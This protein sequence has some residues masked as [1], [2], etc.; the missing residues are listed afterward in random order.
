MAIFRDMQE[1]ESTDIT[2]YPG[3]AKLSGEEQK[4]VAETYTNVYNNNQEKLGY[5][6]AQGIAF[7]TAKQMCEETIGQK[8]TKMAAGNKCVWCKKTIGATST[9]P[10]CKGE[11]NSPESYSK[12]KAVK[13]V[14]EEVVD[15]ARKSGWKNG[16]GREQT[17]HYQSQPGHP[18]KDGSRCM[19]AC[20][21]GWTLDHLPT[22]D[23]SK[24]TCGSCL[25]KVNGT[26]I[27]KKSMHEDEISEAR[28]NDAQF[29]NHASKEAWKATTKARKS[30]SY[31]DHFRAGKL[32]TAA[33]KLHDDAAKSKEHQGQA[34]VHYSIAASNR[35]YEKGNPNPSKHDPKMWE[36]QD[37]APGLIADC[38]D[39][40]DETQNPISTR[41]AK[42][43]C[44]G[45]GHS[46]RGSTTSM[47][48]KRCPACNSYSW[49]S[50]VRKE[51]EDIVDNKISKP[52]PTYE[53]QT[54][55]TY[56]KAEPLPHS[57]E[58][59]GVYAK[60]VQ[61]LETEKILSKIRPSKTVKEGDAEDFQA[62]N[63]ALVGMTE[64]EIN[65]F[66]ISQTSKRFVM[67]D[68]VK[69][70]VIGVRDGE[71]VTEPV[72]KSKQNYKDAHGGHD[73][74]DNYG[75]KKENEDALA[76]AANPE[77]GGAAQQL[78]LNHDKMCAGCGSIHPIDVMCFNGRTHSEA[79]MGSGDILKQNH[80]AKGMQGMDAVQMKVEES[81]PLISAAA[82]YLTNRAKV[83]GL[84][85][86]VLPGTGAGEIQKSNLA[87]KCPNC[88][89]SAI[90]MH[91]FGS[92]IRKCAC[93]SGDCSCNCG[94]GK[95]KCV[96]GVCKCDDGKCMGAGDILQQNHAV[97]GMKQATIPQAT[98]QVKEDEIDEALC[99]RCRGKGCRR[100]NFHFVPKKEKVP[101]QVKED[102]I[103]EVHIGFKN[104]Q[105]KLEG[106]GH[107]KESAGNICHAI[108]IKKYGHAVHEDEAVFTET[109]LKEW[110]T[111][112]AK[113]NINPDDWN[114]PEP[115]PDPNERDCWQCKA[116]RHHDLKTHE[117]N[118]RNEEELINRT[119]S[120]EVITEAEARLQESIEAVWVENF[121]PAKP[122]EEHCGHCSHPQSFHES[123]GCSTCDECGGFTTE[124]V[125]ENEKKH[126]ICFCGHEYG[127]HG[128]GGCKKCKH[129]GVTDA[130]RA[131]HQFRKND[132]RERFEAEYAEIFAA[133]QGKINT[134]L[135]NAAMNWLPEAQDANVLR[136]WVAG[137]KRNNPQKSKP[138]NRK[139]WRC[140]ECGKKNP[141]GVD[142]C[143]CADVNEGYVS[144]GTRCHDCGATKE[145]H[146]KR[147][148]GPGYAVCKKFVLSPEDGGRP[149]RRKLKEGYNDIEHGD[150]VTFNHP[151]RGSDKTPQQGRGKAVMRGPGGWVVNMGGAHGTPGI[152]SSD[153]YVSHRKAKSKA[154]NS[155]TTKRLVGEDEYDDH[156]KSYNVSGNPASDPKKESARKRKN[157]A[158]K[159]RDDIRRSM[160]LTKV[161]GAVSGKT[162]WESED[163]H[164]PTESPDYVTHENRFDPPKPKPKKRRQSLANMYHHAML[165]MGMKAYRGSDGKLRYESENCNE[166]EEISEAAKCSKCGRSVHSA[167]LKHKITSTPT[168]K[169]HILCHGCFDKQISE[170][171]YESGVTYEE[172]QNAGFNESEIKRILEID[173]N[174]TPWKRMVGNIPDSM[175]YDMD[176][177]K[178]APKDRGNIATTTVPFR[179]EE[180]D[181]IISSAVGYINQQLENAGG[182]ITEDFSVH[183]RLLDNG[184]KKHKTE[185][186]TQVY[187][188]PEH[189]EFH[190]KTSNGMHSPTEHHKSNGDVVGLSHVSHSYLNKMGLK[191]SSSMSEEEMN[192]WRNKKVENLNVL[193]KREIKRREHNGGL[194]RKCLQPHNNASGNLCFSCALGEEEMN[195]WIAGKNYDKPYKHSKHWRSEFADPG[196]NSSLR[197]AS[198]SNPR[199][200]PC[201]TCKEPNKLTAKDVAQKYQCNDCAD[202]DERC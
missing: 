98:P 143:E 132:Y 147:K 189:G 169:K 154:P 27:Y 139:P 130:T 83:S 138:S 64:D 117:A 22:N 35:K 56:R 125:D 37:P 1:T 91:Q 23:K 114:K 39:A 77:E 108:M 162:Y 168:F 3:Y 69:H 172:L 61:D 174:S 10:H 151:L 48:G 101:P 173:K 191:P 20:G 177:R 110:E 21:A 85:E 137:S 78:R 146:T 129:D 6:I 199:N 82:S 12:R 198:K 53:A 100:C 163:S 105:K 88:G 175:S 164:D 90:E 66:A 40:M 63:D 126:E 65:E 179:K 52:G 201:P 67:K 55:Y 123:D 115:K 68:G 106:K 118:L 127:G 202:R 8:M 89:A 152:V 113:D 28:V 97:K 70:R 81:D 44:A 181:P 15:E 121:Y 136:A 171:E 58:T 33:A 195:E 57:G 71:L 86:S 155:L 54:P 102:E 140:A 38:G 34:G 24:V 182:P 2:Q 62:K 75:M 141:K 76:S 29:A 13:A 74:V 165:D 112:G 116:G 41:S 180:V 192:E 200:K 9:C 59:G 149:E 197:A 30:Q 16:I 18:G 119:F 178:P 5:R 49:K 72:T 51:E 131:A 47:M 45:C 184:F 25:Q 87:Q 14:R 166:S 158:R 19:P 7:A 42:Y 185:N 159:D 124:S 111:R 170:N 156:V 190:I 36:G 153:N 187:S 79:G 176:W 84:M 50:P 107:S 186:Q 167:V 104:L 183:Q 32:H 95:C 109:E 193:S 4:K 80:Q 145:D 46:M 43:V 144:P 194:C 60:N 26:G 150:H 103:D 160:G 93:A 196:G 148:A 94:D 157:Q 11:Q 128:K 17:V 96:D 135:V 133:Q 161:K 122:M 188:H 134:T 73:W 92:G 99:P 31:E 142:R 120:E